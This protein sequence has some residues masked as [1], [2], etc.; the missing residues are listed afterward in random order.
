MI[1]LC[2]NFSGANTG[3]TGM[4]FVIGTAGHIDHGKTALVRALTGQDTDTLKAEKQRGI[5]IDLGF[6]SFNL[7]DGTPVGIVDVPGHERFI[8]NMVA[9]AH[10]LDLVLFLVAA[11]DGVMPQTEEHFNIVRAL[12]IK[13]MIFVISKSDRV[14]EARRS[15]VVE[16]ID[17]LRDDSPFEDAEIL[18]VDSLSGDGITALKTGIE[19]HLKKVQAT[20]NTV[21]FRMPVDRV[22]TIHGRGVVVTGTVLSGG[23]LIGDE[24][25]LVPKGETFRVRG[26]QSH[27]SET[28]KGQKGARLAINL[29]AANMMDFHR[30]DVICDPEIARASQR[31]DVALHLSPNINAPLKNRQKLRLHLGTAERFARVLI[32][33]NA[34]KLEGGAQTFAQ[35][36]LE[37]PCHVMAGD[38]FV[39]RDEQGEHT[40]GGG[41]VL[42]PLGAK[43]RRASKARLKFLQA[44]SAEN[45]KDAIVVLLRDHIELGVSEAD[46][47]FRFGDLDSQLNDPQFTRLE[48]GSESWITHRSALENLFGRI[49][50]TLAN[51]HKAQ[52]VEIGLGASDLHRQTASNILPILFQAVLD[53]ACNSGII[54]QCGAVYVL[55]DHQAGLGKTQQKQADTLLAMFTETPFAP[56]QSTADEMDIT[57]INYLVKEGH[58]KRLTNGT[59]FLASAFHEA[60]KLLETHLLAHNTITA[61]EY[62]DSLGTS[63]KFALALLETFDRMGRTIRVGDARKRG[64]PLVQEDG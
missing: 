61:A 21:P 44:L 16:E 34:G 59:L 2:N 13:Q 22:F 26:L 36:I 5:S 37:K 29:A 24:V 4:G 53:K 52:P 64:K 39:I 31:I 43:S 57:L 45:M 27:G 3:K 7:T 54:Q 20:E 63:R 33:G 18:T 32:L 15:E 12:G 48:T 62:R 25:S 1:T 50:A 11:D 55:P 38:H 58:L 8:R 46:L 35:M 19:N 51:F 28:T 6:A 23:L 17:L 56:P 10:G 47:R 9:G 60:D 42:D 41:K 49:R 30:G 14:D 40:L